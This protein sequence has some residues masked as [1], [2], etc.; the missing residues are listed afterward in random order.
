M[1][2]GSVRLTNLLSAIVEVE[3]TLNELKAAADLYANYPTP[4]SSALLE[5]TRAQLVLV[6]REVPRV[7]D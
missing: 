7:A 6:S 2:G 4:M 3:M 5:L 1:E